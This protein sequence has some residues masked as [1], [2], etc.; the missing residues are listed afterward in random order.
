MERKREGEEERGRGRE[1]ERERERESER[2]RGRGRGRGSWGE[3]RSMGVR[4]GEEARAW[5]CVGLV[6]QACRVR[7]ESAHTPCQCLVAV[8]VGKVDRQGRRD[9]FVNSPTVYV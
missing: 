6:S 3:G 5:W 8:P 7:G 4:R 2:E 1:R 9:V